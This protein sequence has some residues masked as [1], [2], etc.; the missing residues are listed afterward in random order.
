MILPLF[1]RYPTN[2]Q[3]YTNECQLSTNSLEFAAV[4]PDVA[5]MKN[6]DQNHDD[7]DDSYYEELTNVFFNS[8]HYS[9]HH[10]NRS[11]SYHRSYNRRYH[12]RANAW[13][14]ENQHQY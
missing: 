13:F 8:R 2:G 11:R 5:K 6:K 9:Y 10:Y 1:E 3:P 14:H 4:L 7:P 12:R